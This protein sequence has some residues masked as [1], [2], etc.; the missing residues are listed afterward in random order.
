[1]KTITRQLISTSSE[2][3]GKILEE[4]SFEVD[5]DYEYR[6]N[7]IKKSFEVYSSCE[8]NDL[9]FCE[10]LAVISIILAVICLI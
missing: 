6:S 8:A 1:M 2:N 7:E 9:F 10:L 4:I 5:D 3:Y